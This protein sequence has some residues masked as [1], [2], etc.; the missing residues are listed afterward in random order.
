[1]IWRPPISIP[2]YSSAASDVYKRQVFIDL[3]G[4]DGLIHITDLSWG[5]V[6][7]P[8]EVVELDQKLNVV[9]LDFDDEKKRIALGLKQ[10]TPHPWDALDPNLKVGDHV[11]GKVVVMADYGA[12][13]EI[14]PGVEGL[15]HVS[16]MSWSQ[17]L[18][19]AQDFMKVGLSLIHIS[20]P[21]RQAEISYAVFCLKKKKRKQTSDRKKK[22]KK[23]AE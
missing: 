7:D 19:S 12:F 21:T 9:I 5:R 20:E 3:G 8:K 11:K 13:I 18:R 14:A 15:I 4:V 10:L 22:T 23:I 1:M 17:H 16:E 2:L 6:S